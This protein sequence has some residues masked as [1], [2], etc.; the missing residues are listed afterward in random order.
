MRGMIV[1]ATGT[2]GACCREGSGTDFERA[3]REAWGIAA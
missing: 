2:V 3:E 1:V